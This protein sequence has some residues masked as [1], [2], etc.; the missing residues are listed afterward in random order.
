LGAREGT[1]RVPANHQTIQPCVGIPD[2]IEYTIYPRRS[3]GRRARRRAPTSG[4]YFSADLLNRLTNYSVGGATCTAGS[5]TKSASYDDSGSITAKSDVGAYVYASPGQ[6]LPHAVRSI[7]GTVNGILNPNYRYDADGNL[8]CVYTGAACV[9]SGIV[10]ESDTYWSFNMAKVV[11]EGTTSVAFVYDSEHGRV[12]QT[13]T[14]GSTTTVTTYL[15]DVIAGA[16]SEKLVT[17]GTTTWNDYVRVDGVLI[18]ERSYIGA[19]PCSANAKWQFFVTDHLGSVAVATDGTAG[20]P[21]YGQVTSRMAFDPWGRQRNLDGS[22]DPTCSLGTSNPTTRGFT[23]GCRTRACPGRLLD[24]RLQQPLERAACA[25]SPWVT[26]PAMGWG[27]L[28]ARSPTRP[29]PDTGLRQ[30]SA[31]VLSAEH[32]FHRNIAVPVEF[33]SLT[34]SRAGARHWRR[35]VRRKERLI[36]GPMREVPFGAGK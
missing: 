6:P 29:A 9:G 3:R 34:T 12:T 33:P 35:T 5:I 26:S 24:K 23:E 7:A 14:S 11:T 22:D 4:R 18:G 8:I 32:S 2:W 31:D 13:V 19:A 30:C 28:R 10:R 17:A 27:C 21:T 20:S 16:M 15:N 25:R 1:H 36:C